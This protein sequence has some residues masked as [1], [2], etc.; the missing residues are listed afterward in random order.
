M[1]KRGE[2]RER[3]QGE[4][5]LNIELQTEGETDRYEKRKEATECYIWERRER[6]DRNNPF[7]LVI[8]GKEK[9]RKAAVHPGSSE[10]FNWR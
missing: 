3:G 5:S 8:G 7:F 6:Q 9:D 4:R 1:N 10:A 2:K